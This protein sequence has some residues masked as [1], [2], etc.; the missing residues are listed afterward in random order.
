[1]SVRGYLPRIDPKG[2]V[3][4]TGTGLVGFGIVMMV[5]GAIMRFA[6]K[7][8]TSGFNI[9]TAGVIILIA[10]AVV[11]LLGLVALF[12]AARSRTT[13]VHEDIHTTPTG[14]ERL[15]ERQDPSF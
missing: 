2:A 14:R 4:S 8:H 10:G 5:V 6:V 3:M 12:L 11:F 9:H 1:M 7:V 15:E 13:T